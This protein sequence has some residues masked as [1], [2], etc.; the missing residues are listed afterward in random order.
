MNKRN[1]IFLIL[2]IAFVVA[3][4]GCTSSDTSSDTGSDTNTGTS[5]DDNWHS[6]ANLSGTDDDTTDSFTIKG[7]KLKI[8][9]KVTATNSLEYAL[10]NFFVYPEGE[11]TM[12]E[13]FDSIDSFNQT[14][15]TK[16]MEINVSPGDY[17]LK[18]IAA[19]VDWEIEVFDYY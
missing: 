2:V 1:Y 17:Y 19:N 13:D 11:T 4:S 7:D 9:A 10:F 5:D 18:I 14:T 3:V 8:K 16:E 12:Y 15:E 6:V